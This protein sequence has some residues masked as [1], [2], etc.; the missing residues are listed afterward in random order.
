LFQPG[1]LPGH[2][3]A[4]DATEL[5]VVATSGDDMVDRLR[6]GEAVSAA[7]LAAT[8]LGLASI[9]LSQGVEVDRTRL[10]LDEATTGRPEHDVAAGLRSMPADNQ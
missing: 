7:L 2:G 9:P 3:P 10:G 5:L 4:D 1:Q 6:A 8:R